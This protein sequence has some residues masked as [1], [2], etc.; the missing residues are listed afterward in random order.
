M[1][2]RKTYTQDELDQATAA[3][4]QQLAA[5]E[6]LVKAIDGATSDP[7]VRAA[8]DAFE[9]LF[10]N[11]MT[12]VLDRYFVHRIR[13]VAGKDGNPLNE[14]ELIADSL[15]NNGGV[16]RGNKVIKLNP[17]ESVAKLG[18]GE[19]ISLGS[20]QFERLSKAFLGENPRQVPVAAGVID[21]G[22]RAPQLAPSERAARP[23]PVSGLVVSAACAQGV[24]GG[25][26]VGA[27]RAQHHRREVRLVR[28]VRDSAGSR[29]RTRRPGGTS[30]RL[31]PTSV[32]SR[33]LPV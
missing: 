21:A 2:G 32:P 12:I 13:P 5:Y 27:T 6:T 29:G 23:R 28:R 24:D 4:D 19:K 18:F 10:F 26:R 30:P 22:R 9:P 20:T 16:M 14:V 8:L 33:K 15:I 7:D 11:N 1:L 17:G 3:V 31:G 25:G